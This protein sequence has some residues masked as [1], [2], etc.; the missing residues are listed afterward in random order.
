MI[1]LAI[2]MLLREL[3]SGELR[4]LFA[5]LCVAVAAV[6]AVGFLGDRVGKSLESEARQMLGADRKCATKAAA[7]RLMVLLRNDCLAA[8]RP[9][10]VAGKP[11]GSIAIPITGDDVYT[12]HQRWPTDTDTPHEYGRPD[13]QYCLEYFADNSTAPGSPPVHMQATDQS[14]G[15]GFA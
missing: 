11:I 13:F 12:T 6:M 9:A 15:T 14:T 10:S 2:R 8:P 7:F 4:L 3:R 5:T 1:R